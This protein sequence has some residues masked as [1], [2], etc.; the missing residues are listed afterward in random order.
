M[1]TIDIIADLVSQMTPTFNIVENIEIS[2][3]CW[4]LENCSTF[5]LSEKNDIVIDSETY[6]I[7]SVDFNVS[8]TIK[9]SNQP[10]V[11]SFVIAAPYFNYGTHRTMN[12]ERGLEDDKTEITPFVYLMEQFKETEDNRWNSP[13]DRNADLRVFFMDNHNA[14]GD[15]L[16]ET[17]EATVIKPMDQMADYMQKLINEQE[18]K[19]NTVDFFNHFAWPKWGV[20]EVWGNKECIFDE[21]LS[22]VEL[23]FTLPILPDLSCKKF[24]IGG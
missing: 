22:G 20:P 23:R 4:R 24:C 1:E 10:T 13:V 3:G 5:W 6:K 21:N 15:S 7:D 9:G 18:N 14:E 11:T 17:I 2:A 16:R 19:F 12:D 8:I